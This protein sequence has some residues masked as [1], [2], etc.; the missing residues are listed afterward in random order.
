MNDTEPTSDG[1]GVTEPQES[2]QGAETDPRIAAMEAEIAKLKAENQKTLDEAIKRRIAKSKADEEKRQALLEAGEHKAAAEMGVARI[3]ELEAQLAE[4]RPLAERWS[5]HES[6]LSEAIAARIESLPEEVRGLLE[7]AGSV[8][9]K[10]GI[11]QVFDAQRPKAQTKVV[12]SGPPKSAEPTPDF[13]QA[14]T[15]EQLNAMIDNHPDAFNELFAKAKK[16][17]VASIA[18]VFGRKKS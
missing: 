8:E 11:L 6:R 1:Q 17:P 14:Q 18:G 16:G 5:A 2:V 10:Q 13:S 9:V 7:K 4:A 15:A 12:D 3:Q